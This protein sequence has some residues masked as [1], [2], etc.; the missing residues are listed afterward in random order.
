M[1]RKIIYLML[2]LIISAGVFAQ[3]SE[4]KHIEILD[5]AAFKQKVWNFDKN[6]TF[7]REGKTPILLDFYATWCPPCKKLYPHLQQLQEKYKGKLVIYEVD[8]DKNPEI[9]RLFNV[10]AMPTLVFV[11]SKTSYKTELGYRDYN[12]LEKNAVNYFFTK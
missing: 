9:A 8:V 3:N 4:A 7:T 5:A 6:K 10:Q 12:E 2:G 1:K 11:N